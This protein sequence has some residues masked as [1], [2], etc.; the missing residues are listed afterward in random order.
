MSKRI[1][2]LILL[3]LVVMPAIAQ[4]MSPTRDQT[5]DLLRASL[6][7]YG[8]EEG[9]NISFK[10]SD[11][12]PY[13][14]TGSASTGLKNTDSLE[15]VLSVTDHSTISVLVYPH[16]NG[17]YINLDKVKDANGFMR[18]LLMYNYSN[19]LS[20]GADGTNDVF[21]SF[22]FTLESGY[23]DEAVHIV[24]R[25][26]RNTDQFVGG[27]RPFIDGTAAQ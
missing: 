6:I 4:N 14:F 19:F 13:N 1:G 15:V 17:G 7:K 24:L 20:W 2:I 23:P 5:R 26:I 22:N 25:S 3:L 21:A 8:P 11:K 10:Q 27:L 18:K 16:Y 9:V 12:Q